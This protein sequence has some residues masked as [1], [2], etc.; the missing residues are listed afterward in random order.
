MSIYR[1][2]RIE[3]QG[4][5]T[6]GWEDWFSVIELRIHEAKDGSCVTVLE[7]SAMDQTALHGLLSKVRDLNLP[8]LS[9]NPRNNVLETDHGYLPREK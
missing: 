5:L 6:K 8:L 1:R 4:R 2:Y 3:I 7:S 9:V